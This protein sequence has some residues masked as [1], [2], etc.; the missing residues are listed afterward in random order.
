MSPINWVSEYHA[1]IKKKKKKV[2]SKR[3]DKNNRT[4]D[5][6]RA[7]SVTDNSLQ[8]INEWWLGLLWSLFCENMNS[9]D[10]EICCNTVEPHETA[11]GLHQK[12]SD[13]ARQNWHLPSTRAF[14][15]VLCTWTDLSHLMVALTWRRRGH[16]QRHHTSKVPEAQRANNCPNDWG[17]Y[18]M[19]QGR[20]P[21]R[22]KQNSR[23]KYFGKGDWLH[24]LA[25]HVCLLVKP[26]DGIDVSF[27]T[28]ET[29]RR[30]AKGEWSPFLG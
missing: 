10:G 29:F 21:Q 22:W 6:F 11:L 3:A 14:K 12:W 27:Y 5:I 17:R 8:E 15:S 19:P 23:L 30:R 16:C 20:R 1:G 4:T 18:C 7:P 9:N 13:S 28:L 24:L 25:K 2:R 26:L